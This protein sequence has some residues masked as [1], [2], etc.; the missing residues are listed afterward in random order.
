M[1]FAFVYA[2]IFINVFSITSIEGQGK[3]LLL[4]VTYACLHRGRSTGRELKKYE[5]LRTHYS[6]F[7]PF[8]F[9]R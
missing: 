3:F 5:Q 2:V 4:I 1:S 9:I 6:L 7:P 8:G